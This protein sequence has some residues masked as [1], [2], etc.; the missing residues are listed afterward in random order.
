MSGTEDKPENYNN[1]TYELTEDK[2]V[3]TLILTQDGVKNK[4]AMEHSERNWQSVFEGLKKLL[5]S[6]K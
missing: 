2:G 5:K 4:E 3:T 6:E 1:I